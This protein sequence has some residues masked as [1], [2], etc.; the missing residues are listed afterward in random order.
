ML[1]IGDSDQHRSDLPINV[2]IPQAPKADNGM[3]NHSE[4]YSNHEAHGY[5]HKRCHRCSPKDKYL[6]FTRINH[7][8]MMEV[9]GYQSLPQSSDQ[10]CTG[11]P[12]AFGQNQIGTAGKRFEGIALLVKPCTCLFAA[13][14]IRFEVR[15]VGTPLGPTN[16]KIA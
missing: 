10:S 12:N 5:S 6:G 14:I 9:M 7:F 4:L 15:Q 3:T 11:K 8:R 16:M 1:L 2:G 13:C